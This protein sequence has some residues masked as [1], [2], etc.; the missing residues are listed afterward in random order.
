[1]LGLSMP[2]AGGV[3]WVWGGG[4]RCCHQQGNGVPGLGTMNTRVPRLE[5]SSHS[6][7]M[8]NRQARGAMTHEAN[9]AQERGAPETLGASH[10]GETAPAVCC[11]D[12]WG[13][14]VG[15]GACWQ[16]LTT[17]C[18]R[19]GLAVDM[20]AGWLDTASGSRESHVLRVCSG[21]GVHL[22]IVV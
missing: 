21:Q 8:D 9:Q 18:D 4:G 17:C 22:T 2:G 15:T 13:R 11:L 16:V 5:S 3:G 7:R 20:G 6:G 1:M 10:S 12:H 14:G 19:G